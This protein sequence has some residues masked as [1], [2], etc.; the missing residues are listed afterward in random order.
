MFKKKIGQNMEV[1]MED[2]LVKSKEPSHH[3]MDLREAFVVLCRYRILTI[4]S[5]LLVSV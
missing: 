2:L 3:V 1:Y 5:A 4:P